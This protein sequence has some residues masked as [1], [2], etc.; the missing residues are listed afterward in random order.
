MGHMTFEARLENNRLRAFVREQMEIKPLRKATD[1][2]AIPHA[3][4]VACGN[5]SPTSL[6]L[7]HF[8][9][10][11]VSAIDR[12]AELIAEARGNPAFDRVEFSVGDVRSLSFA[13]G[14]FDA[15]FDL[16]DLHNFRDW[17]QGLV[18]MNRV[19][20][21]GGLLILEEL[22]RESF[23]RSTGRLFKLLTDHPYDAMLTTD[24]LRAAVLRNGFEVLHFGTKNPFGLLQYLVM[25]ARKVQ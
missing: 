13:D 21:P 17:E 4:H 10:E 8:S 9:V 1:I 3:L 19:L 11:K 18:E 22:T 25:I 15:V 14:L 24:G 2:G 23:S 7:E 20:K 5:G 6:I 16:A 12:D